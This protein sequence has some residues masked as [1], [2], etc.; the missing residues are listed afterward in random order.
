MITFFKCLQAKLLS[1][2][3]EF[4][5]VKQIFVF[6]VQLLT[7]SDMSCFLELSD[8]VSALVEYLCNILLEPNR[9]VHMY[10]NKYIKCSLSQ[11]ILCN[12]FEIMKN[13]LF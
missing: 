1:C 5:F 8:L 6:P 13:R 9:Q 11:S 4:H 2:F 7:K 12:L 10:L 3:T